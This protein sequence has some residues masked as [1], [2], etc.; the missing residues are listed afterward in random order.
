MEAIT[1]TPTYVALLGIILLALSIRVVAVVRAKGGI[2]YGDGGN[3]DYNLVVRGQANFI[4]YVP[5]AVILIAFAEA[6]GT[7]ALWIH[8]FGVALVI[9]R[10]LHP[11]GL[12]N[13][14]GI[15]PLRF[16]GTNL[17]WLTILIASIW[18]LINQFG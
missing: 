7:P 6:G 2:L 5:M 3:A 15:N 11:M 18:V 4:E 13:E 12:T 9:G 8:G 10:I 14:D 17:T 1:I 16:I